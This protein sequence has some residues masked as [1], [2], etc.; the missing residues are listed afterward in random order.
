[1]NTARLSPQPRFLDCGGK[2]SA[3]PLSGASVRT[4]SGVTAALCH[5]SPN[6]CRPCAELHD[7]STDNRFNAERQS[8]AGVRETLEERVFSAVLCGLG[9]SALRLWRI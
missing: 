8:S 2:R 7:C 9:V 1:M 3:T 6:L 4:K 5:R